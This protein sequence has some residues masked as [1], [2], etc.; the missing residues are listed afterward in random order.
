[1]TKL[2]HHIATVM[3]QVRA[4]HGPAPLAGSLDAWRQ[5]LADRGHAMLVAAGRL[6]DYLNT[7]P[8]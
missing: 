4:A 1:M 3:Q 6:A 8:G 2:L 5:R 7:L